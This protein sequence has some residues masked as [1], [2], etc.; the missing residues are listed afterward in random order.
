MVCS[1]SILAPVFDGSNYSIWSHKMEVY[2]SFLGFDV[3]ISIVNGCPSK[4]SPSTD[5]KEE[6]RNKCNDESMET[7]L[8]GLSGD[9]SS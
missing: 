8:S 3:W 6:R 4:V 2:L 5:P 9:V 7:I 1:V